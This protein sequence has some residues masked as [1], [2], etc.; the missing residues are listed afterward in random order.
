[1]NAG[2]LIREARLRAG[3]SQAVLAERVG[4]SHAAISRWEKGMV[5]PTWATV[6]EAARACGLELQISLVE[7]DDD[8]LPRLRE[9]LLRTPE[10]R[11]A[12]LTAFVTFVERARAARAVAQRRR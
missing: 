12:D 1:M 11:L 3:L 6:A 2:L 8:E 7:R 5:K 10:Q 4:T 9:R